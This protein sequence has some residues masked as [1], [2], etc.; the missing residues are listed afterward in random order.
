MPPEAGRLRMLVATGCGIGFAP[1][2]PGTFGSIPG[3]A[4]AWALGSI[5]G[6]PAVAVGAAVVWA[7]G[8]AARRLGA[9]D[10]GPVVVDEIAGQM[11]TL[12][13]VAPTPSALALGFFVFRVLDVLKPFPVRRLEAL[14]GGS[15]IMADDLAAG[16]YGAAV[17]VAATR[18]FPGLL[19]S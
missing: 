8:A 9:S 3:V 1:V 13:P 14:P 7:A 17:M 15:G 5:G 6:P 19:G 10:P 11:L 12:L 2:A 18:L 16:V 4:L